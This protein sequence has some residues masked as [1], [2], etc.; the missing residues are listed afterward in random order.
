MW[1][2][3]FLILLLL[4][5]ITGCGERQLDEEEVAKLV[6]G[7]FTPYSSVEILEPLSI[8]VLSIKRLEADRALARVCYT[9]KF[10]ADYGE[11]VARIKERPNSFLARFDAGL[12]ALLARKFGPFRKGDIKSRCD[13]VVLE[14]RYGKWVIRRI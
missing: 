14:R 4:L 8:D 11:L 5:L 13:E 2:R 10:R 1:R 12:I 7:Y 3:S 9:F 6:A